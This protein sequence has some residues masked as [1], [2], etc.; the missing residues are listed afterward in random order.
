VSIRVPD[1]PGSHDLLLRLR[2]GDRVVAENQYPVHVVAD[3]HAP[4][5]I[6]VVGDDSAT[7][8]LASVG[9]RPGDEGP[10]VV[11]EGGLDR[12]DPDVLRSRLAD[13][14]TVLVLAHEPRHAARYPVEVELAAVET[15]WGSSV[16]HFT[17]DSGALPSFPRRNLLVAEESTVQAHSVVTRFAGAAFPNEPVVIAYKPVPGSITGS[18]VGATPVGPGRLI[19]CQ[20]RL[21][22]PA[23]RGD[24]AACAL[25][26]D[27]ITW[28][29]APRPVTAAERTRKP[30][31]RALTW[32]SWD[33][34]EPG[35]PGRRHEEKGQP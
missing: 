23:A 3:P 1:V 32:Y 12:I 24:A 8:L 7:G 11:A 34:P 9:A 28:A 33:D 20:Y 31:G 17:T 21:L 14:G 15:E 10:T 5:P 29:A 19:L 16:F 2:I 27:L 4:Y 35:A 30:D 18:V 26:A 25:L 22:G 6:Q 13:G